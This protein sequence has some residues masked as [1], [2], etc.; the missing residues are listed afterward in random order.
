MDNTFNKTEEHTGPLPCSIF[1]KKSYIHKTKFVERAE[2]CI[3]SVSEKHLKTGK[4]L[5][6]V[7]S[8]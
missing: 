3:N 1:S 6:Y 8:I 7:W 2:G 5:V 4:T